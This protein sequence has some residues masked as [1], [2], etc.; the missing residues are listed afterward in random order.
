M[1]SSVTS[2]AVSLGARI[3]QLAEQQPE[4]VGLVYFPADGPHRDLTYRQLDE[5]S[6]QVARLLTDLGVQAGDRVGVGLRN[7]PEHVVAALGAWKL[8]AGIVTMRWDVPAWERDR[9]VEVTTPVVVLSDRDDP[10]GAVPLV[11]IARA[12]GCSALPVE[13][14]TPEQ[15]MAI[16]TGGSTGASK[17]VVLPV[18][19]AMVPGSVFGPNYDMFGIPTVE[20]HLVMGPMYHSN[21]LLMVHAGLFDGQQLLLME[22]FDGPA[23]VRIID[24]HRPQFMT[25]VPT[26]MSRLLEVHGIERVDW[27]CFHMVLH[28]TAPCP[29]WLKRRW[30]DLVGPERLWEIFAS[31][32]LVG[33]MVVRGDEWL[34]HPGTI[35]KPTPSTELR[36]LDDDLQ[37]VPVGEVGEVYMRI[38]GVETPLFDYLGTDRP[39]VIAGGFVSVGDLARR[40]A[41]GYVYSADRRQDLIITG[42]A[43]VVPAEVEAAL[44]EHP[45]VADVVVIGLPDADWGQRVHAIVQPR[46]GDDPPTEQ[47]LL[48]F[49]RARLTA[50]KAPKSVELVDELP[51]SDMF[52]VRR[53]ALVDE[54][55]TTTV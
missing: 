19:G 4:R 33:S 42:G 37:D 32:E 20:R 17:A 12:A 10:S 53:S 5:Q 8:G 39:K 6:N 11:D 18:P 26:T 23:L 38:A 51:R 2:S 1:S 27:S 48:A 24:S 52:K 46:D 3:S 29:A 14:I 47:D 43:N 7:S 35:G 30:I 41:D 55:T 22:R 45:G 21:P 36:L 49:A 31:S 50:Y 13:A 28:G 15:P 54:R 16:P 34:E 25:L 40:D 44:S 9:L